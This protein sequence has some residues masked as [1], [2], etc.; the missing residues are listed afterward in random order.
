[1][2]GGEGTEQ[3][4]LEDADLFSLGDETVDGLLGNI[5]AGAHEDDDTIGI[6]GA[7]VFVELVLA[8]D[9]RAKRS[10]AFCRMVGTAR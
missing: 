5:A 4:N 10:I 8:S 6:G 9:E 7:D 3:A 2:R 1:M